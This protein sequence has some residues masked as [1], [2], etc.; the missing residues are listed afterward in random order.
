[1]NN[2]YH[3]HGLYWKPRTKKDF[4]SEIIKSGKWNDTK[5]KLRMM[6]IKQL[7]QVF[8]AIRQ[9]HFV[10]IMRKPIEAVSGISLKSTNE[11]GE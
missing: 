9:N 8:K 2:P 11:Q 7:H 1:M 5:S 10:E 6:D 4:I 3:I